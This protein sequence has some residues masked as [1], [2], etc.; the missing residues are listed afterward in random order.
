MYGG[1]YTYGYRGTNNSQAALAQ[2]QA[3][4]RAAERMLVQQQ[5]QQQILPGMMKA[6]LIVPLDAYPG[7]HIRIQVQGS[8]YM[9]VIPANA[10]PGQRILIQ[11]PVKPP[12]AVIAGVIA[13]PQTQPSQP[14]RYTNNSSAGI[15]P[16]PQ[17]Q[18][19]TT[20]Y[21][22]Q[23]GM[24]QSQ[25]G[26]TTQAQAP[27]D[28]VPFAAYAPNNPQN[29]GVPPAQTA[30]A[31]TSSVPPAASSPSYS[32]PASKPAAT[33]TAMPSYQPPYNPYNASAPPPPSAPT[34]LS[35]SGR[36]AFSTA[37]SQ[38]SI[39]SLLVNKN[40]LIQP[41]NQEAYA[42]HNIISVYEGETVELIEGD[43]ANG[44]PEPYQDY[45]TVKTDDGRIGKVAKEA[46]Q[47]K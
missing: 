42:Q 20:Q 35:E 12:Q 47:M 22:S 24:I 29:S 32:I 1:G 36:I 41:E 21:Q 37:M 15:P 18:Y 25:Y 7:K 43:L 45:V 23:Y 34:S 11:V 44:L 14:Q 8:D 4:I 9:V 13:A 46:L 16:V 28:S 27:I 3:E 39:T 17:P 5:H 10:A 6:E 40:H 38:P 30:G 19:G 26:T 2:A 33:S 31:F